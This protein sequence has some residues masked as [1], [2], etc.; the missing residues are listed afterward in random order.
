MTEM[1]ALRIAIAAL[2]LAAAAWFGWQAGISTVG[3]GESE[4]IERLAARYAAQTGGAIT[5]CHGEPAAE[6]WIRVVCGPDW[7]Y[8]VD[9]AGGIV[10][11]ESNAQEA[12]DG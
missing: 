1:R 5:D 12:G 8:A 10:A 7:S 11:D 4:V 2:A 9:R 3:P 6:A